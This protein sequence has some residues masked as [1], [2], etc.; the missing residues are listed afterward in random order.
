MVAPAKRD[1]EGTRKATLRAAFW[2][3]YRQ[4]YEGASLDKILSELSLTK[5]ALYHHFRNKKALG[6]AVLDEIIGGVVLE[7]WL[8]ACA[9]VD[10]PVEACTTAF[11]AQVAEYEDVIL[12]LGCPL[13]NLAQEMSAIDEDF[14][15]QVRATY[16]KW[17][18]ALAGLIA[19]G[20][21]CGRVRPDVDP[22]RAA[23]FIV[24]ATEGVIGSAKISKSKELL[25]AGLEGIESYVRGLQTAS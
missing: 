20:Q 13:N 11:R 25:E 15:E 24:A 17:R 7:P 6:L 12:S 1:P 4:G 16:R 8:R 3:I 19:R 21:S 2:E 14:R 23:A 18:G 22:E 9:A 5:G 10:V